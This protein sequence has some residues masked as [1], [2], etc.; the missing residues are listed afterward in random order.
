M[1][2][3]ARARVGVELRDVEGARRRLGAEGVRRG[4]EGVGGRGGE[5]SRSR[6]AERVGR[7]R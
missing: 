4:G 1:R 2:A 6:A 3:R 5:G 7:W